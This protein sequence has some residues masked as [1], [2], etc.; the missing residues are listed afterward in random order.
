MRIS[1]WS[2]D[3]CSSD[4]QE[5]SAYRL[6]DPE[7]SRRPVRND[8]SHLLR[9]WRPSRS[10][11]R[12]WRISLCTHPHLLHTHEQRIYGY[13][14]KA[15]QV[16]TALPNGSRSEKRRVGKECVRTCKYRWSPYH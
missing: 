16:R 12:R 5:N 11:T 6:L 10:R 13:G 8:L 2:S 15:R 3:V 1:D 4:L 9:K 14:E 7:S